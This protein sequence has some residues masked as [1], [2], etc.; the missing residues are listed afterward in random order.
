MKHKIVC[1]GLAVL[2]TILGTTLLYFTVRDGAWIRLILVAECYVISFLLVRMQVRMQKLIKEIDEA[3]KQFADKIAQIEA[4]FTAKMANFYSAPLDSDLSFW[5]RPDSWENPPEKYRQIVEDIKKNNERF[6]S[7]RNI[8]IG[9]KP[10]TVD[11]DF[12]ID[13]STFSVE[14]NSEPA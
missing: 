4:E 10:F 7:T 9:G 13:N 5:S 14:G 3:N 2:V 8:Y 12:T 6:N 1:V 11:A